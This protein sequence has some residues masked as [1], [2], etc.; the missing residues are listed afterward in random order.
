MP[1]WNLPNQIANLAP[2]FYWKLLEDDVLDPVLDSSGNGN[3]GTFFGTDI[4]FDTWQTP[5]PGEGHVKNTAPRF[6]STATKDAGIVVNPFADMPATEFTFSWFVRGLSFQTGRTFWSY[7][8]GVDHDLLRIRATGSSG[9]I[10]VVIDGVTV[11]LTTASPWSNAWNNLDG[12][13]HFAVAWRSSDGRV[14]LFVNGCLVDSDTIKVGFSFPAGGALVFGQD[15]DSLAG[16]YV[17]ADAGEGTYAHIAL[18]ENAYEETQ[19]EG[20]AAAGVVCNW[21]TRSIPDDGPSAIEALD[22]VEQG[23]STFVNRVWD[24]VE[25]GFVTW[26]TLEPDTIGAEYPGPGTFG[27]DT[28]DFVVER[29]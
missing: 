16:T 5:V 21:Q 20:I 14:Q 18:F 25:G 8:N 10:A 2:L 15:Q 1:Q 7:S 26:S 3:D 11:T 27:V 9:A 28:S 19:L 22:T 29:D 17:A 12:S 6:N 13:N 23:G 24:T 4:I